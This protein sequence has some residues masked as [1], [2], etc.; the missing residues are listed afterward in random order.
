MHFAHRRKNIFFF[1]H[2]AQ[3]NRARRQQ[4]SSNLR[5]LE[6]EQN[7]AFAAKFLHI[8]LFFKQKGS[9]L[10]PD[11]TSAS[12]P[13]TAFGTLT[14]FFETPLFFLGLDEDPPCE[15]EN[16]KT[17][18][19]SRARELLPNPDSETASGSCRLSPLPSELSTVRG[20]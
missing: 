17:P 6:E 5:P 18:S 8:F 15:L 4:S 7:P 13:R 11:L 3:Q 12:N 14:L 20:C 19:P 9:L 2:I 10:P 1:F 16:V